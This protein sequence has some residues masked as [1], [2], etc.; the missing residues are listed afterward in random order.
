VPGWTPHQNL[1]FEELRVKY[2][3]P[4]GSREAL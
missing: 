3:A 1:V 2:E 4:V